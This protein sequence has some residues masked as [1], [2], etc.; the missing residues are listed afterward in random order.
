MNKQEMELAWR[1]IVEIHEYVRFEGSNRPVKG[2]T[3]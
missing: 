2:D 1:K 3:I